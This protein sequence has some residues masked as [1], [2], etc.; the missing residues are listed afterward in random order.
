MARTIDVLPEITGEEMVYI[1]QLINDLDDEKARTFANVYR[2]RRKDPQLILI[3]ALLGFVGFAGIH[4]MI[5]NQIGMGILY[6][7]TAGLCFVGTILD[8]VNYQKLAS[9]HNQTIANETL[10]VVR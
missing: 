1:Q 3:L 9:E 8:L 4:R 7:F 10:A 6:F 2:N 5:I